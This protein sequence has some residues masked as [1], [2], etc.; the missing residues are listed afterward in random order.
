MVDVEVGDNLFGVRKTRGAGCV[1]N[2]IFLQP[3]FSDE[4]TSPS[5][6]KLGEFEAWT[7]Q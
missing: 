4:R 7:I 5:T 1:L 2:I 6:T 3:C